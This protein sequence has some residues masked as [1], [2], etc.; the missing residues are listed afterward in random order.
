MVAI[1]KSQQKLAQSLKLKKYRQKHGL[2]LAEGAKIVRELIDS[3][4]QIYKLYATEH[5]I[6]Q[7]EAQVQKKALEYQIVNEKEL[8]K[9]SQL[10]TANAAVALVHAQDSDFA[11]NQQGKTLLL[12]GIQDPGNLGTILRIADWFG[13]RQ[14]VGSLSTADPFQPKV[15]QASMGSIFRVQYKR[16]PL[17]GLLEQHPD[18][19]CLA[20]DIEG[21][22]I[23]D[24]SFP[25][26]AFLVIG[27]ESR[28]LSDEVRSQVQHF[29]TI[30]GSGKAESLN[31]G[32]ATGII[33]ALWC[34]TPSN[35]NP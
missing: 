2:F 4:Y 11:I 18:L 12:D 34:K 20:A 15:V 22:S 16:T 7:N 23:H 13:I 1:S 32:V 33:C 24:Y 5:W 9:V 28:G 17:L 10:S 14:V 30:P 35:D 31:A 29:L 6:S 8:K 19:I 25:D 3:Q 26:A 27:N 21:S